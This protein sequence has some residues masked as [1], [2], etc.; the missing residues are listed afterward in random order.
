M[1][2][3]LQILND[4]EQAMRSMLDGRQVGIWTALPGIIQSV[5]FAAMTCE[6][7]PALQAIIVD[8]NG[9]QQNVNLPLLVDVPIVF[10]KGGGF[11][12]TMP[13][14][15]GDEV[16]VVFSSRC[17]DA[18]FQSGGVQQAMEARMHDL[19][20]GFAIPGCYSQPTVSGIGAP[21]SDD[22]QVRNEAGTT[23]VS[24]TADGKVKLISP[25]EIDITAPAVNITGAVVVTGT[26]ACGALTCASIGTS[27]SGSAT[28]GGN[29]TAAQVTAGGIGLSTH[30]HTGVTTGGG[31]SGGPTP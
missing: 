2:D 22:L 24:V 4:P 26:L 3:R 29:L 9:V 25:S 5:D 17:I 27:G 21:S 23:Y 7:Q 30:K 31:T 19:S 12:I 11:L 28:I 1:D 16:L 13:L 6:V 10:P 15:E 18:W 14:D 8:N 20:D